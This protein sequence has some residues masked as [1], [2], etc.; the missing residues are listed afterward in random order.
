MAKRSVNLCFLICNVDTINCELRPPSQEGLKQYY[1]R[2]AFQV[3]RT[4]SSLT[5][6]RTTREQRNG[7]EQQS[8]SR[9]SLSMQRSRF[10]WPIFM[11]LFLHRTIELFKL[12]SVIVARQSEFIGHVHP[13]HGDA[14]T[15]QSLNFKGP[16]SSECCA[17][18]LS[19]ST[20]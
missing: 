4:C 13:A 20:P 6:T 17:L 18:T 16:M 8:R 7:V 11:K 15:P 12:E 19:P 10:Y 14:F 1:P 5:F 3:N 2:I 9:V